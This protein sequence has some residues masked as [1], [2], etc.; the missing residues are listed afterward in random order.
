M[1]KKPATT[2]HVSI[3]GRVIRVTANSLDL[4]PAETFLRRL[5]LRG[6]EVVLISGSIV[7]GIGTS[8]SDYDLVVVGPELPATAPADA[9]LVE[10]S[11]G[12]FIKYYQAVMHCNRNTFGVDFYTVPDIHEIGQIIDDTYAA[13]VNC[14]R[15]MPFTLP[16]YIDELV[17]KLSVAEALTNSSKKL[18]LN[19]I[20]YKKYN[21]IKYRA[22]IS[23]FD[24]FLDIVGAWQ[25]NRYE[26]CLHNIR[27]LLMSLAMG[28][29]HLDGN[30]NFKRKWLIENIRRLDKS[31]ADLS[32]SLIRWFHADRSNAKTMQDGIGEACDLADT[33]FNK[34][35]FRLEREWPLHDASSILTKI[36]KEIGAHAVRFQDWEY[37]YW[38]RVYELKFIP[39][40][41]LL[42]LIR[43]DGIVHP[44]MPNTG[45][46]SA[47][48]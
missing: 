36:E 33:I 12:G 30:T 39:L 37:E 46:K 28:L 16:Q 48:C 27:E 18:I 40:R 41:E 13:A 43:P 38:R 2:G 21:F 9:L 3:D 34:C 35:K 25:S 11:V 42:F 17:H 24:G 14:G 20:D 4:P 47:S 8:T 45:G 32:L 26:T 31:D 1:H 29:C 44:N 15:S 10:R 23:S 7:E 22:S 6:D 19:V 5:P